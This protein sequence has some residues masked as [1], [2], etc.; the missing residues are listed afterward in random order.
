ML[1]VKATKGMLEE[2]ADADLVLL[3]AYEDA[4]GKRSLSG[5]QVYKLA[6]L[7]HDFSVDLLGLYV[8]EIACDGGRGIVDY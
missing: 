1:G 3:D 2:D 8:H 6:L 5:E 7:A 4:S